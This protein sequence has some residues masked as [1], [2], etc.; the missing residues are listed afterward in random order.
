MKGADHPHIPLHE[1]AILCL[2]PQESKT[3]ILFLPPGD[4]GFNCVVAHRPH[5]L[6]LVVEEEGVDLRVEIVKDTDRVA[7]IL[8]DLKVKS[9]TVPQSLLLYLDNLKNTPGRMKGR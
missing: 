4:H 6:L 2:L 7:K 9:W 8:E 3:G 5:H 1:P